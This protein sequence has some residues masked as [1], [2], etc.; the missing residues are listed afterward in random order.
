MEEQSKKNTQGATTPTGSTSGASSSTASTS[1]AG[2][3]ARS[4]KSPVTPVEQR[5]DPM[6][7]NAV[8]TVGNGEDKSLIKQV[9][10]S[11]SEAYETAATKATEKLEEKKGDLSSSL[12]NVAS[13]IRQLGDNISGAGSNDQISRMTS[14][15]SN[16]AAEKIERAASYFRRQDV[17]A[18]YRDAERF[19][20]NNPAWV[21]GGAFALG[22]FAARFLKS[23][24]PR[25][26][27]AAAGRSFNDLSQQRAPLGGEAA[28]GL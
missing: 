9:R 8:N 26:L 24:P 5:F 22:F 11:A 19:A 4:A 7:G 28:R 27:S 25:Q 20:R 6:T 16:S 21:L 2:T 15:F 12:S 13:G 18:M 10:S 17:N 1:G 23:T 3:S 14:E